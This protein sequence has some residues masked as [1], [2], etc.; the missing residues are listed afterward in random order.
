MAI[1]YE[2]GI[3]VSD[4][5]VIISLS[6]LLSNESARHVA[7]LLDL[8]LGIL[9]YSPIT[10][11]TESSES[12]VEVEMLRTKLLSSLANATFLSW[13]STSKLQKNE[14]QLFDNED[15][16]VRDFDCLVVNLLHDEH[17]DRLTKLLRNV[18]EVVMECV[19]V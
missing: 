6:K 1:V 5:I 10:L 2:A 13:P 18:E 4:F 16:A 19:S 14:F 17:I 8:S 7:I 3:V 15:D 9:E 11:D 12:P